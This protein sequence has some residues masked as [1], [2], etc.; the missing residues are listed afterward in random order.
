MSFPPFRIICIIFLCTHSLSFTKGFI[1]PHLT[2][3]KI[4]F[5]IGGSRCYRAGSLSFRLSSD[6][7]PPIRRP[8]GISEP[9]LH[10][11]FSFRNRQWFYAIPETCVHFLLCRATADNYH[12][13]TTSGP[14]KPLTAVCSRACIITHVNIY[15]NC[16]FTANP[17]WLP[18]HP[19][20]SA[21]SHIATLSHR[22]WARPVTS[23]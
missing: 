20:K 6:L 19:S 16:H 7:G 12:P 22:T 3:K 2:K 4:N 8:S 23:C 11:T 5:I 1:P 9:L 13:R 15:I 14:I 21:H 17:T 18:R 10:P